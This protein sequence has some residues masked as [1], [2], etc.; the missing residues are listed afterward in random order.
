MLGNSTASALLPK[1]LD[2]A[3]QAIKDSTPLQAIVKGVE[4]SH[5]PSLEDDERNR[6][7][8]LRRAA[9]GDNPTKEEMDA[10]GIS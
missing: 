10:H 1:T 2:V 3:I 8:L 4:E 7:Y 6:E 9:L 5:S